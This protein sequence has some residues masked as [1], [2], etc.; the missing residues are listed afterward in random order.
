VITV[1]LDPVIVRQIQTGISPMVAPGTS[2]GD[3]GTISP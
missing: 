1:H 2:F 3:H